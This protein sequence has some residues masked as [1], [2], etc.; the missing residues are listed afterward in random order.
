[1][2]HAH[3]MDKKRAAQE[4]GALVSSGMGLVEIL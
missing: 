1:M 3:E 4:P 2:C